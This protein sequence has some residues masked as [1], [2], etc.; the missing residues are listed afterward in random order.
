MLCA[1]FYAWITNE[2]NEYHAK[3]DHS[4]WLLFVKFPCIIALHFVL[5]PEVDNALKIMKVANQQ[6]HLFVENGSEVTFCLG[7]GQLFISL[8]NMGIGVILLTF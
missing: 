8:S 5:T 7:L 6:A 3:P 1:Q 4:L 2:N